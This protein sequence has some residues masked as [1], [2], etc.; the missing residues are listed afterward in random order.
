[1]SRVTGELSRLILALSVAVIFTGA[2]ASLRGSAN[3]V[4]LASPKF[5]LRA[6]AQSLAREVGPQGVHVSHV[7]VDG[8]VDLD[9]TRASYGPPAQEDG[10][11]SPDAVAATYLAIHEQHRSA[12]TQELDV[13]PYVRAA[14][15]HRAHLR[16][17]TYAF[18]HSQ[19]EKF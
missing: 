13:R 17:V 6:L 2:T 14:S 16:L 12:W 19:C 7:I 9:S 11:L 5:A 10:R 8:A 18:F 1:M 15:L 3:F 4:C